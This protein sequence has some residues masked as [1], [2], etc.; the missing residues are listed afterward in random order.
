VSLEWVTAM[1]GGDSAMTV[2]EAAEHLGVSK[3]LIYRLTSSNTLVHE[4]YGRRIVLRAAD[5]ERFRLMHRAR[6]SE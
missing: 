3:A 5:V 2:N 4:R 1:T 6:A